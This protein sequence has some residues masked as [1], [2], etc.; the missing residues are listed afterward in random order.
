MHLGGVREVIHRFLLPSLHLGA[1]AAS[2]CVGNNPRT[3][4]QREIRGRREGNRDEREDDEA[5]NAA[6]MSGEEY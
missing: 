4:Q 5:A 1:R 6:L 2:R 3:E